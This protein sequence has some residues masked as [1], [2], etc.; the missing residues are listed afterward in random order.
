[1]PKGKKNYTTPHACIP[2]NT[3]GEIYPQN[4]I[5]MPGIDFSKVH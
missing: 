1:M 4:V 5:K 2:I 3:Q